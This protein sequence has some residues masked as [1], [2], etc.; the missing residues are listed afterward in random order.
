MRLSR[1]IPSAGD[2]EGVGNRRSGSAPLSTC[3]TRLWSQSAYCSI[4]PPTQLSAGKPH[5]GRSPGSELARA[6]EEV[7]PPWVMCV[8]PNRSG[9]LHGLVVVGFF[10]SPRLC[11][12]VSMGEA[13]SVDMFSD[14]IPGGR[15]AGATGLE[16]EAFCVTGRRSNQLNY[17][18]ACAV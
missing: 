7:T 10:P 18:L 17:A 15:L 11:L 3:S 6:A 8:C 16:P 4:L 9:L 5:G 13:P 12:D 1:T 2:P 14:R